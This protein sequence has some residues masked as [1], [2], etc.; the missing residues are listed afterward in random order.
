M[1]SADKLRAGQPIFS[2]DRGHPRKSQLSLIATRSLSC[3]TTARWSLNT[4]RRFTITP[5]GKLLA[6]QY[7]HSFE[8]VQCLIKLIIV[9]GTKFSGYGFRSISFGVGSCRHIF[10][11]TIRFLARR[12]VI[13]QVLV[14]VR[15][16]Q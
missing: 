9:L 8:K 14:Q 12:F 6:L 10:A 2:E 7:L 13:D 16:T 5:E 11:G 3:I 1:V 4:S 15:F